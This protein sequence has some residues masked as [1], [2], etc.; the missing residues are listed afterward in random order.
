M[1]DQGGCD[2]WEA[3]HASGAYPVSEQQEWL[4]VSGGDMIIE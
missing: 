3:V 1:V 2:E 4:L